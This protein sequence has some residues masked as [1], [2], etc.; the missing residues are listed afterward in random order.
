M[1]RHATAHKEGVVDKQPNLRRIIVLK[2]LIIKA[3]D[4]ETVAVAIG[5][6]FIVSS[7]IVD[8]ALTETIG[9]IARHDEFDLEPSILNFSFSIEN[10]AIAQLKIID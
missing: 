1:T 7:I 5:I 9:D 8:Q 2:S 10:H 3:T 4:D 6:H